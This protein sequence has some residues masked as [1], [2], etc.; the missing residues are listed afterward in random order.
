MTQQPSSPFVLSQEAD[1]ISLVSN[2]ARWRQEKLGRF[3]KRV[4]LAN[5]K[6]AYLR[7]ELEDWSQ[8]PEGWRVRNALQRASQ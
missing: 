7:R 5:R 6:V 2:I 3:P 4:K 1:E 8:D